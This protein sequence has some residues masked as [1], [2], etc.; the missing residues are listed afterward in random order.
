MFLVLLSILLQW[1]SSILA[2]STVFNGGFALRFP[3]P[4]PSG[5]VAGQ[6]TLLQNCCAANQTF[7]KEE[8][9]V[10]CPDGQHNS[11]QSVSCRAKIL[12]RK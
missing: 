3:G 8:A 12:Y 2:Q 7:V 1:D 6:I 4:C 9:S 10:C 11:R 5:L